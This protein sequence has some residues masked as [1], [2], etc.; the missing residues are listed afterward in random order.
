MPKYSSRNV[1]TLGTAVGEELPEHGSLGKDVLLVHPITYSQLQC[2]SSYRCI[3]EMNKAVAQ[4]VG[5]LRR[6]Q[7]DGNITSQIQY[8]GDDM[9]QFY[10]DGKQWA[11]CSMIQDFN[12]VDCDEG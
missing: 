9:L 10:S 8:P 7:Y 4:W 1:D 5:F 6:D 12:K 3:A 11:C 2:G